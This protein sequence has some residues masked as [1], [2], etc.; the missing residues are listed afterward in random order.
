MHDVVVRRSRRRVDARHYSFSMV[1]LEMK[2][3]DQLDAWLPQKKQEYVAERMKAG[4]SSEVAHR[5]SD[6]QFAE[7]FPNGG[8]AD[9]QYVMNV[10]DEADVV[11]NLWMG[12]SFSG[13]QR[14]WF[15]FDIEI[16]EEARGRGYGRAAMEAA[17]EWTRQHGGT[18]IALNVFGP[19]VVARSLYDSL[20][21]EV[22]TTSMF[23]DL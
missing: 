16:S 20:G 14:T 23:K 6:S 7:L 2:T 13:D 10:V 12:R 22:Q 8:P 3:T 18:R 21:Y 9:G 17:E 19:N 11:G 5:T 15:V 1:R 4:E